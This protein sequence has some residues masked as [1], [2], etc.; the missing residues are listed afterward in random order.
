MSTRT[1]IQK[2]DV[3]TTL[4]STS[5]SLLHVAPPKKKKKQ[6]KQKKRKKTRCSHEKCR[7]ALSFIDMQMTCKCKHNYCSVHRPLANHQCSADH[8]SIHQA[9]LTKNN[10]II[11]PSKLNVV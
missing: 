5:D 7:T 3:D 9:Y 1:P 11:I 10:P 8:V 2:L 4:G 6:K